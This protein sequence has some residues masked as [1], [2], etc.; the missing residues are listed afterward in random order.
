MLPEVK[1][2][3]PSCFKAD[4]A[5][6][7]FAVNSDICVIRESATL[8]LGYLLDGLHVG[9]VAPGTENHGNLGFGI[10]VGRS[11]QCSRGIACE[12]DEVHRDILLSLSVGAGARRYPRLT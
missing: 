10:N 7:P 8:Q 5:P 11:D 4:R 1:M 9:C 12:G 6:H 2:S 3:K